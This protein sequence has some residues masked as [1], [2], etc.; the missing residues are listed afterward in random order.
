MKLLGKGTEGSVFRKDEIV[1]KFFEPSVLFPGVDL[2]LIVSTHA[3]V[4]SALYYEGFP[5]PKPTDVISDSELNESLGLNDG[6]VALSY[7]CSSDFL[8]FLG[9]SNEVSRHHNSFPFLINVVRSLIALLDRGFVFDDV[10]SRDLAIGL[11]GEVLF[12]D[13]G[14]MASGV[15]SPNNTIASNPLVTVKDL[16]L[17]CLYG[18]YRLICFTFSESFVL[19]YFA[20][21][22]DTYLLARQRLMSQEWGFFYKEIV[23]LELFPALRD[24]LSNVLSLVSSDMAISDDVLNDSLTDLLRIFSGFDSLSD[25][26][27]FPDCSDEIDWG[28]ISVG[29]VP[30]PI[31]LPDWLLLDEHGLTWRR[32]SDGVFLSPQFKDLLLDICGG[33]IYETTFQSCSLRVMFDLDSVYDNDYNNVMWV[34]VF[35]GINRSLSLFIDLKSGEVCGLSRVSSSLYFPCT[36]DFPILLLREFILATSVKSPA[37]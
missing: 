35:F 7:Y 4:M 3:M 33:G 16:N 9:D 6:A 26:M 10:N 20:L 22:F 32:E 15:F 12:F 23:S 28:L 37:S 34:R 19:P 5:C 14:A 29:N 27:G 2:P 1:Y 24:W 31:M 11:N 13:V 21:N 25:M 36:D 30:R 8:P 17:R 18:V